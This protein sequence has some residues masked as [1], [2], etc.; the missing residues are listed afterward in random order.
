MATCAK[1]P[2]VVSKVR[3]GDLCEIVQGCSDVPRFYKPVDGWAA[4]VIPFCWQGE[5]HLFYLKDY[6]DP[7]RHGP[8]TP[9]EH[10]GTRDFVHFTEHPQALARGPRH[11]QD[12][13]VFT[14]SVIEQNG[15]FH[16][17]YTGHNR[18]LVE[19]R[20]PKEAVMHATSTDLIQWTKDPANP[21]L[22]AP[23]DR[24]ESDDWRDPFVF[25]NEEDGEYWMLLA[26]RLRCGPSRRRGCVALA[27]SPDLVRWTVRDPFWAPHL[28]YTHECPDL[29]RMGDWWYLVYSTFSERTV[30]HYRMSR[31]L[32]GPWQ[33]P[34]GDD[35]FDDRAFYAAKTVSDGARRF[36][37][38]WNPTRE[39]SSD[40]GQW[41]CG[42]S[43]VFHE[44]IQAPDGTLRVHVP[45]EVAAAFDRPKQAVFQPTIGTWRQGGT[46]ITGDAGNGYAACRL[47]PMATC[48]RLSVELTC[49]PGT[50]A[51]G[52]LLHADEGL[53][54]YYEVRWEPTAGRIVFDR[55]PRPGDQPFML[56]RQLDL[57]SDRPIR[58][59]IF[60][61]DTIVEVYADDRIALSARAYDHRAGEW[62]L[63]VYE[64]AATFRDCELAE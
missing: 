35:T 54:T 23:L 55:W 3:D 9:W 53:D 42:G 44:I 24:Y 12:L 41:H 36:A 31:S 33:V 2:P 39:D 34:Q 48:C 60:A 6:R 7:E 43:L 14:G 32:S 15:L 4:D 57:P 16:I 28:Y 1:R 11:A 40:A 22:L 18:L 21:I 29:F 5:Y 30:T 52:V 56:E 46:T 17:F 62:G 37:C 20:R 50:R 61:D 38:G 51:C 19:Q 49:T 45:D 25:W 8:G 26:A 10:L 47:G 64:G 58:L 63:F 27:S 59:Q 13:W